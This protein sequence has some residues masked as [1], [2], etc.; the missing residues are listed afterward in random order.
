M[1]RVR[2]GYVCDHGNRSW[3]GERDGCARLVTDEEYEAARK[4]TLNAHFTSPDVIRGMWDAMAHLG[5]EGGKALEPAAGVGH[6]IGLMPDNVAPKTAWTATELDPLTAR[7]AKA[8]YGGADVNAHGFEELKR[9]SN[10]FD[11][12]ISNVPFGGWPQ[13]DGKAVWLVPDP[14]FLFRQVA[15]Q[16]AAGWR[17]RV[18]HLDGTMDKPTGAV[19]RLLGKDTDLVGAIR[20]PGGKEGAFAGM[21]ARR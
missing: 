11:L 20:L 15:R 6:F 1:G 18:H 3:K 17:R 4:S 2:P 16:G 10:Y 8:L 14:R 12:A 21:P 7:L 9:P 13:S 5:Y 19:R